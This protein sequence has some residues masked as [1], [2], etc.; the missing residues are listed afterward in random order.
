[1]MNRNLLRI[2]IISYLTTWLLLVS[3][4]NPPSGEAQP[5]N[6]NIVRLLEQTTFGPTPLLIAYLEEVGIEA[7]LN[8]QHTAAMTNYPEL[9]F[10]PQTRPASCTGECQR[11][12]Y[13]YY[14]LQRHFFT[15]ALY[16]ED[17]LRQRVAF[18]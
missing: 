18:A 3:A 5:S 1:M 14:Q 11:D 17:Q 2:G 6:G 16:G 9:E 10:W 4:I 8:A 7:Y 15:N 12:N 13:T